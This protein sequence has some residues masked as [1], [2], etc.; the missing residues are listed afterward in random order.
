MKLWRT[1]QYTPM[2]QGTSIT[3]VYNGG[4]TVWYLT[5]LVAIPVQK[6]KLWKYIEFKTLY[7]CSTS[8]HKVCRYGLEKDA[9]NLGPSETTELE[10]W[11]G[12]VRHKNSV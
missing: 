5:Q 9:I 10:T 3:D 6:H 8:S 4:T 12:N 7:L 11:K 1:T 2:A